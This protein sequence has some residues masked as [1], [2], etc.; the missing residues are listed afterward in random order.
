MDISWKGYLL[1]FHS[2]SLVEQLCC[3]QQQPSITK[4]WQGAYALEYRISWEVNTPPFCLH[5]NGE[6]FNGWKIQSHF[7]V[8]VT[9][10]FNPYLLLISRCSRRICVL[11]PWFKFNGIG[12]KLMLDTQTFSII[13]I[14]LGIIRIGY[15]KE[16]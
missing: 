13:R 1:A 16:W 4:S 6:V 10:F 3:Q 12:F 11:H 15:V 8:V 5:I 2:K 7:S 9:L 14:T